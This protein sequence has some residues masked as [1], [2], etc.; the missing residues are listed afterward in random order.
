MAAAQIQLSIPHVRL[1]L[2]NEP[3]CFTMSS[4]TNHRDPDAM[5]RMREVMRRISENNN[6]QTPTLTH[7]CRFFNHRENIQLPLAANIANN[8]NNG[9]NVNNVNLG[10]NED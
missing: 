10:N 8:G 5:I 7:G 9:H 4:L 6:E 1:D 2:M 3:Q